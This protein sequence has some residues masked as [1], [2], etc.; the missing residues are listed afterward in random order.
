MKGVNDLAG[1]EGWADVEDELL[2]ARVLG[3]DRDAYRALVERHQGAIYRLVAG[4]ARWQCPPEELAQE[5]FVAA[6]EGLRGFDPSRGPFRT[7]LLAI[8]RHRALNACKRSLPIPT[9]ELPARVTVDGPYE[10]A[11][12]RELEQRLDRALAALPIELRTTFV[13]KEIVGLRT[14]AIATLEAI[15]VASVRSRLSRARE[16]LRA[17]LGDDP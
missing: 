15:D 17:A 16:R 2:V 14:E 4:L 6:Y 3:G 11:V 1:P 10:M 7:W 8:A 5:V 12:G 13:L 9:A